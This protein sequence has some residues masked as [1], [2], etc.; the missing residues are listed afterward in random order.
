[1]VQTTLP[2][3]IREGLSLHEARTAI[4][5]RCTDLRLTMP[6]L[7]EVYH[8]LRRVETIAT[9]RTYRVTLGPE[10]RSLLEDV[11]SPLAARTREIQTT[12]ASEG[13]LTTACHALRSHGG[14]DHGLLARVLEGMIRSSVAAVG[15]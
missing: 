12:L 10:D 11:G 2:E 6:M 1:M 5:V 7:N 15:G 8:C 9:G 14:S 3:R 4:S 13:E